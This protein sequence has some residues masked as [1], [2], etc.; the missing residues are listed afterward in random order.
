MADNK[1]VIIVADTYCV[2][3]F[4]VP[5]TMAQLSKNKLLKDY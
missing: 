5:V 1:C 3:F 2:Q 4:I